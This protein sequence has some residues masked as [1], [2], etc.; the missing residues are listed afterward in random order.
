MI[1]AT[2]DYPNNVEDLHIRINS[3][4]AG[5]YILNGTQMPGYGY[6]SYAS[7]DGVE[8]DSLRTGVV[9]LTKVDPVNN[10]IAGTFEFTGIDKRSGRICKI[11]EGRFDAKTR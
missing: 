9:V 3:N 10:I 1:S 4:I 5:T 11:T 6:P 7:F 2:K 8:T